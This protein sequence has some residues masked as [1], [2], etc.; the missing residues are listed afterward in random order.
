MQKA[1]SDHTTHVITLGH[2]LT[3]LGLA[4]V[5]QFLHQIFALDGDVLGESVVS[6]DGFGVHALN[7]CGRIHFGERSFVALFRHILEL[8]VELVHVERI[9]VVGDQGMPDSGFSAPFLGRE[10][11]TSP[12]PAMLSKRSGCPIMTA[13]IRRQDGKYRMPKLPAV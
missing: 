9:G 13:T 10:A 5:S 2:S 12:L 4:Q 3:Y 6:G 11:W 7:R 1:Q 8:L